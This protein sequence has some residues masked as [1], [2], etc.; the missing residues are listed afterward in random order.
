M[1]HEEIRNAFERKDAPRKK[2]KSRNMGRRGKKRIQADGSDAFFNGLNDRFLSY[3][4]AKVFV[5]AAEFI[6]SA[7]EYKTWVKVKKFKFL[8]LSA[9]LKYRDE[10]EGWGTFLGTGNEN[11]RRIKPKYLPYREAKA[12]VH[13]VA[14]KHNLMKGHVM[15]NWLSFLDQQYLLPEDERELPVTVPRNPQAFYDEWEGWPAW[16][17]KNLKSKIDA[18]QHKATM[19]VEIKK[20]NVAKY[21]GQP[22]YAITT[23][24][25]PTNTQMI[26]V[27]V[28]YEGLSKLLL[29][30][31]NLQYD[32]TRA[33]VFD[34]N[35]IDSIRHTLDSYGISQGNSTYMISDINALLHGLGQ[36]SI[37]IDPR[38]Y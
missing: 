5:Q 13:V 7:T 9:D 33:Y 37:P 20:S 18:I 10:W 16:V 4:Q 21:D 26:K 28:S 38:E 1:N 11:P 8:P 27:I 6:T 30:C 24:V 31:S 17:G 3:E 34:K 29:D 23:G 22:V 2:K 15:Q 35:D 14:H 12:L 25:D 36:F 19:E 32:I